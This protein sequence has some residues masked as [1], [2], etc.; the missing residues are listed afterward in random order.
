MASRDD[1]RGSRGQMAAAGR[2]HVPSRR[3]ILV[4]RDC[5]SDE[6][7]QVKNEKICGKCLLLF[8]ISGTLFSSEL[9]VGP[10]G[11]SRA[12]GLAA[13]LSPALLEGE[14][15]ALVDGAAFQLAVG[16][17]GLLHG[18]GLVRTQ[19]EPAS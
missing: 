5:S 14:D 6:K 4:I 7:I 13:A 18:H 17:G 10:G 11:M 1:H 15:D 8:P 16:L 19:A 3:V 2:C 9:H 12:A